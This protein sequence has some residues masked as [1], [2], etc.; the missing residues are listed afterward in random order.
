MALTHASLDECW[1]IIEPTRPEDDA[2][3]ILLWC[4]LPSPPSVE[5]LA[6]PKFPPFTLENKKC[7]NKKKVTP[8][9]PFVSSP[10]EKHRHGE[11]R[12]HDDDDDANYDDVG[13]GDGDDLQHLIQRHKGFRKESLK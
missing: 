8:S 10:N 2:R 4:A 9:T 13:D 3:D 1:N 5:T 11:G 6:D 12:I 7:K